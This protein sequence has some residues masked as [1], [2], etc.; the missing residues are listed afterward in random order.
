MDLHQIIQP[1]DWKQPKGYANAILANGRMLFLG[2]QIGWLPDQKF[3]AHD[4]LGQ[5]EQVLRNIKCLVE[6]AGGI[7]EHITRMTWF[8]TEKSF[9]TKHQKEIGV[10]YRDIMGYHFPAMTMVVVAALVE[11]EALVEIEVT[12]VLPD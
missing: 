6:N 5:L 4:F 7:V 8:V 12:A 10:I 11:D 2:G 3:G 9:Y 1:A